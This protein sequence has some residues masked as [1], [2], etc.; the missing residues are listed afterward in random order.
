MMKSFDKFQNQKLNT[1]F[2]E[3]IL[4]AENDLPEIRKSAM[5]ILAECIIIGMDITGYKQAGWKYIEKMANGHSSDPLDEKGSIGAIVKAKLTA[6]GDQYNH[7]LMHFASAAI[8]DHKEELVRR[9]ELETWKG[10]L[11]FQ[12]KRIKKKIGF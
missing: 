12:L 6:T 7:H 2:G 5:E 3:Y 1:E 4:I 9:K 10:F 8:R 11:I